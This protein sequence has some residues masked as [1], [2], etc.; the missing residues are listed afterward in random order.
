MFIVSMMEE[1]FS[2]ARSDICCLGLAKWANHAAI[3]ITPHW[4]WRNLCN[5]KIRDTRK[6][7]KEMR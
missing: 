5:H 2:S 6:I 4:G 3:N 1:S 7:E